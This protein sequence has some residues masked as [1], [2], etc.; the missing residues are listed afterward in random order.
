MD[1]GTMPINWT[2]LVLVSRLILGIIHSQT[3]QEE[4]KSMKWVPA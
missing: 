3:I 2:E 4:V 1:V